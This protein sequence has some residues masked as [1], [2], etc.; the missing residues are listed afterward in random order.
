M[1]A[2]VAAFV[3]GQVEVSGGG[4]GK[5]PLLTAFSVV[6]WRRVS[7]LRAGLFHAVGLA[8]GGDEHGVVQESVKE[9][10]GGGVL[11]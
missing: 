11:G 3:N 1:R 8:L 10:D 5:S 6:R 9:A 7:S 2:V 4:R